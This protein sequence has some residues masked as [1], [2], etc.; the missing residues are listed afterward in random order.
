MAIKKGTKISTVSQVSSNAGIKFYHPAA[1]PGCHCPMHTVLATLFC[2]EQ[3]STLV[4]GTAECGYYSRFVCNNPFGKH[5]ELH[6][7]YELDSNEVV[8]GCRNGVKDSLIQMDRE[9]AKII[10]L[11]ITCVPSLIGED[12]KSIIEEVKSDIKAKVLYIDVAHFKRN[13]YY[14]G[15]THTLEILVDALE[16]KKVLSHKNIGFLGD[17]AGLEGERLRNSLN[18]GG[19]QIISVGKGYQLDK[20]SLVT[21]VSMNLVFNRKFLRFAKKIYE[22]YNIPYV[23]MYH[24]FNVDEMISYYKLIEEKYQISL[25]HLYEDKNYKLA[26]DSSFLKG[27]KFITTMI[28]LDVYPLAVFL[29]TLGME[30]VLF[31]VEEYDDDFAQYKVK[32]KELGVDP[33]VTYLTDRSQGVTLEDIDSYIS[34]GVC[35]GILPNLTIS[36]KVWMDLNSL[37]GLE[38]TNQLLFL[39]DK[40]YR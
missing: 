29:T 34:I 13:G 15:F 7:V 39:L 32:F 40:I 27:K 8:F 18:D 1:T 2:M 28:D 10:V 11:L 17:V 25:S 26:I 24:G 20:L 35:K 4:V 12:A 31:H 9:G 36:E 14:S 16:D 19:I 3:V 23:P 33:M 21:E 5:G 6:Y 38:R 37:Y 22:K 30:P